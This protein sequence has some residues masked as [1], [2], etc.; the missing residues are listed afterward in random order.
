MTSPPR[1]MRQSQKHDVAVDWPF[2]LGCCIAIM[3]GLSAALYAYQRYGG[4]FVDGLDEQIGELIAARARSNAAAGMN[5]SAISLFEEALAVTFMDEEQ[6]LFCIHDYVSILIQEE[7]HQAALSWIEEGARSHPNDAKL[8]FLRFDL[9]RNMG[10]TDD[11]LAAV[12]RWYAVG[13]S[14]NSATTMRAAKFGEAIVY[15]DTKQPEKALEAFLAAH[16]LQPGPDTALR[17]GRLYVQLGQTTRAR[18]L[19]QYAADASGADAEAARELLN[20]NSEDQ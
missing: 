12:K 10:K 2:L 17:A 11:A 15:R 13:E 6:R 14:A 16:R 4:D 8:A 1:P 3:L 18:E 19:L 5:Q 20:K 9:F 7:H